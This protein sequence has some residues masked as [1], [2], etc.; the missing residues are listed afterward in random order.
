MPDKRQHRGMAPAD[1]KL[2][3]P[4]AG[5]VLRTAVA[6]LSW[7]LSRGYAEDSS[8]KVV[9]DRYRITARQQLAVRRCACA[10]AART[11]RRNRELRPNQVAGQPLFIDGFNVLLTL[12]SALSGGILLRGR[13]GCI[14]DMA[15]VHGT[16]RQVSET[17]PALLAAG[18][19]LALLRPAA[20]AWHL[21]RPVS[22][23]GRLAGVMRELAAENDWPWTVELTFNPDR[24]LA[25]TKGVVV[26]ADSG[27]LDRCNA[28]FNL[29]VHLLPTLASTTA[30]IDLG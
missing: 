19:A 16:Y 21:D 20:C 12:E 10:D 5:P 13:D 14:R 28:W 11:A 8:L 30:V 2:F 7:L 4:A 29:T 6:D 1:A 22:N 23:S 15:G 24:E 9:G 25:A 3:A 17:M 26:T 18:A 27:I